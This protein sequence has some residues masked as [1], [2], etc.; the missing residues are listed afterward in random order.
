MPIGGQVSAG[1]RVW[2][3][4][5][6][7]YILEGGHYP[8]HS[9][10]TLNGLKK[11]ENGIIRGLFLKYDYSREINEKLEWVGEHRSW[12]SPLRE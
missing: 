8:P 7:G 6:T 4:G 10:E 5:S 2:G 9:E 1:V 11:Q 3:N 12:K